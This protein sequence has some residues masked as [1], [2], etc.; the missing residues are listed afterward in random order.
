MVEPFGPCMYVILNHAIGKDSPVT[1]GYKLTFIV[2]PV[3]DVALVYADAV[4][5]GVDSA[6]CPESA[7]IVN[8]MEPEY[9]PILEFSKETQVMSYVPAS[10]SV[11]IGSCQ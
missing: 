7:G 10:Q 9:S 6:S 2:L 11:G 8:D 4:R 3:G 1:Q 5:V